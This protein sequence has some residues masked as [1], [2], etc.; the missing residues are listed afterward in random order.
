[1]SDKYIPGSDH[2]FKL[3]ANRF[4]KTIG[5]ER[6]AYEVSQIDADLLVEAAKNFDEACRAASNRH[7]TS[8]QMTATKRAA[9]T[10]AEKIIRRLIKNIRSNDRISAGH[11]IKLQLHEETVRSMKRDRIFSAPD[12][13]FVKAHHDS[14]GA[15]PMHELRFKDS[16]G[17]N[18]A[19]PE[20]A[21]RL[22]LFVGLVAPGAAIPTSPAD[23][24]GRSAWYLR[25]YTKSP[26]ILVPPIARVPM[27]VVYWA[28]WADSLGN[29]GLFSKPAKGWIEGGHVSQ[30]AM[31]L[32]QGLGRKEEPQAI[33][34]DAPKQ[35]IDERTYSVAVIE[36][37]Y[38]SFTPNHVQ[39]TDETESEKPKLEVTVIKESKQIEGPVESEAA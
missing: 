27:Y 20:G 29:V 5:E 34:V 33:E 1:M 30:P 3:L 17:F 12:L 36:A 4:A 25:S 24:Q 7:T 39:V 10:V 15:S 35:L 37:H 18:K 6:E 9:R 38:L 23:V 14:S 21:V 8:P 2:E 28:R 32:G 16:E 19:R 31:N 13:R 26:V 22:E 11:K